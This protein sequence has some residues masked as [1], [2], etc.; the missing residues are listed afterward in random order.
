[1]LFSCRAGS[2]SDDLG[3]TNLLQPGAY[4]AIERVMPNNPL[5]T[6]LSDDLSTTCT[7][8]SVRSVHD[9]LEQERLQLISKAQ[10]WA[11]SGGPPDQVPRDLGHATCVD[12][13][14]C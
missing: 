4:P 1:V 2:S 13:F 11:G 8:C 7:T 14:K 6:L 9:K 10:V 5:A 3:S 12:S